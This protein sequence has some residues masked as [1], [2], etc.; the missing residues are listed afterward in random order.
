MIL[1][2]NNKIIVINRSDFDSDYKYYN[3]IYNIINPNHNLEKLNNDKKVD[4]LDSIKYTEQ[5]I[6]FYK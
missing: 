5:L 3:E 4:Y 6:L 1:R 2:L